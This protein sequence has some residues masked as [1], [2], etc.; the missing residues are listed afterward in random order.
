MKLQPQQVLEYAS[1]KAPKP[2]R[3][4][5]AVMCLL[6]AFVGWNW[7]RLTPTCF[8]NP[9]DLTMLILLAPAAFVIAKTSSLPRWSFAVFGGLGVLMFLLANFHD[10]N[11]RRSTAWND[12]LIPWCAMVAG[13][14]LVTTLMA[15]LGRAAAR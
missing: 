5:L 12:V 4:W 15:A 7:P 9:F 13:G 14:A 2:L 10:N 6:A 1:P 3:I 11:F 8:P